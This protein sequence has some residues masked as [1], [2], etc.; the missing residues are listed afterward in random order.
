[1][2]FAIELYREPGQSVRLT[3]RCACVFK[4]ERLC[5]QARLLCKTLQSQNLNVE[6]PAP[7][8][9]QYR[10]SAVDLRRFTG[11]RKSFGQFRM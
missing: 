4:R 1:M 9:R 11:K 8:S 6:S 7:L 10:D 2:R 3:G 5:I